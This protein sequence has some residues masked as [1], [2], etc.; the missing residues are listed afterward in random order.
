MA[1]YGNERGRAFISIGA[2]GD[3]GQVPNNNGTQTNRAGDELGLSVDS[4]FFH[5]N[6]NITWDYRITGGVVSAI[7]VSLQG[8]IDGINFD[9][10]DTGT[11]T[12]GESRSVANKPYAYYRSFLT[13]FTTSSGT[14]VITS[15]ILT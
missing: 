3:F 9:T 13:S 6:F 7:S 1:R 5:E 8:S 15:K 14:P 12:S 4:S 10:I 2:I 11:N